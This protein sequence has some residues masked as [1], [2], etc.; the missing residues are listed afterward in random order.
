VVGMAQPPSQLSQ[1]TFPLDDHN[2]H[3]AQPGTPGLWVP[4]PIV[5]LFFSQPRA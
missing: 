2:L 3:F 4:R 5:A 1:F